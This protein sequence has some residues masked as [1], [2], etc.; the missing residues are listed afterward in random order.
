VWLSSDKELKQ[1]AEDNL[2][3]ITTRGF[4]NPEY[5][6]NLIQL[7]Q[8]GHASYYG[9]MIWILVMLEQWLLTHNL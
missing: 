5:I 1:F 6:K 4:L 3:G 8:S 7:H 2:E 9:I